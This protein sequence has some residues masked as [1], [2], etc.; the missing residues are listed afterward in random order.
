[1]RSVFAIVII[2]I[3]I[4]LYHVIKINISFR[5][6]LF[7]TYFHFIYIHLGKINKLITLLGE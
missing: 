7:K 1:M 4:L 5:K 3:Y 6:Y 2:F